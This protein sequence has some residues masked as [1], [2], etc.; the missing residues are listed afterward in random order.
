MDIALGPSLLLIG[1]LGIWNQLDDL[2]MRTSSKNNYKL[3]SDFDVGAS[4]TNNGNSPFII[5]DSDLEG[6]KA[7]GSSK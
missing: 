1:L 3:V 4:S 2:R 5:E 7:L 6:C